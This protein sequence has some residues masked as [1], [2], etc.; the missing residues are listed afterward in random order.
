[1]KK[2]LLFL[3]IF[4]IFS[5]CGYKV[6]TQTQKQNFQIVEIE[7]TGDSRINFYLKNKLN[8]RSEDINLLRINVEIFSE[9]KDSER[10]K[11]Q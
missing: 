6:V 7:T 1:M 11:Y 2:N 10:K 3:L 8:S 5:G 9:K 4:L